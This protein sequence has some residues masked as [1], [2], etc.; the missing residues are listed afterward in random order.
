MTEDVSLLSRFGWLA[1]VVF[2]FAYIQMVV[3]LDKSHILRKK[4]GRDLQYWHYCV[5]FFVFGAIFFILPEPIRVILAGIVLFI[6]VGY[7]IG[8]AKH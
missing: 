4:F 7:Q 6:G 2:I 5:L 1:F 8:K 3:Y